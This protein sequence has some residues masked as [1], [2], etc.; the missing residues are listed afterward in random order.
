M[1]PPS[2][3]LSVWRQPLDVGEAGYEALIDALITV[4]IVF[5]SSRSRALTSGLPHSIQ[6]ATA[7]ITLLAQAALSKGWRHWFLADHME[8]VFGSRNGKGCV[9]RIGQTEK[10]AIHQIFVNRLN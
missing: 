10:D 1:P 2:S 6:C 9:L 8:S 5:C 3:G 4:P 7:R